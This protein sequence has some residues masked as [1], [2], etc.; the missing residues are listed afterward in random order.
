MKQLIWG[1]QD[2]DQSVSLIP[3]GIPGLQNQKAVIASV[4]AWLHLLLRTNYWS[5]TSV[6]TVCRFSIQDLT[7]IRLLLMSYNFTVASSSVF[8]S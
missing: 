1:Y 2:N 4:G 5:F 7:F 8:L 6:Q 3:S